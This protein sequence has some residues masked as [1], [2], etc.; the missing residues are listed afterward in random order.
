MLRS[1]EVGL[2][3]AIPGLDGLDGVFECFCQNALADE[4]IGV[5]A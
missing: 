4:R 2:C 5:C 3:V 1:C